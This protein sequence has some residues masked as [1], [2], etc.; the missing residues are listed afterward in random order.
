[1]GLGL[2]LDAFLVRKLLVPALV[3]LPGWHSGWPGRRLGQQPGKVTSRGER[4][5]A[6]ANLLHS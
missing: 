4:T 1:M 5:T 6:T 3:A 2:L